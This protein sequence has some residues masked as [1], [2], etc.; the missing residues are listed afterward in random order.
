[1]KD[2]GDAGR[3]LV[4]GGHEAQVLDQRRVLGVRRDLDRAGVRHVGQQGAQGYDEPH[5]KLAGEVHYALGERLPPEVRLRAGEQDRTTPTQGANAPS[6]GR[7]AVLG[8]LDRAGDAFYQLDLGPRRLVI[9]ELVAVEA[10]EAF[11]LRGLLDGADREARRLRRVVPTREPGD[12]HRALQ[13]RPP[14]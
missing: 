2:A 7:E 12:E 1:M 13:L 6:R 9:E 14:V 10:S 8:P 3:A 4:A 11:G 5:V